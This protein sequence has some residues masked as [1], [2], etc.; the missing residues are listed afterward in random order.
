MV[1]S[2]GVGA[3]HR[4]HF[5]RT[6]APGGLFARLRLTDAQPGDKIAA[7]LDSEEEDRVL[8]LAIEEGLAVR[9]RALT[10]IGAPTGDR[11]PP[12]FGKRI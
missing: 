1:G 4:D 2:Q 10:S 8:L 3:E 7:V 6:E 9:D 12:Q 5:R 11:R